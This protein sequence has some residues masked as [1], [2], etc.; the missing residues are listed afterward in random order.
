M[1]EIRSVL[2]I[3]MVFF[4][5]ISCKK[6]ETPPP[7]PEPTPAPVTASPAKLVVSFENMVESAPLEFGKKY[8]TQ[9]GDTFKV[10]KFN[11]FI[12]NVVLTKSDNSVYTEPNSYHL[13][14]QSSLRSF[15]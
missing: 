13:I 7:E 15:S 6:E 5:V 4:F 12:S 3:L 2:L 11:Y 14:K 8:T 9:V 10:S 1:Q